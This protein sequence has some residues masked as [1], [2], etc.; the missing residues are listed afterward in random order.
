MYVLVSNVIGL[1]GVLI[2]AYFIGAFIPTLAMS[3]ILLILRPNA[4]GAHCNNSFNCSLFGYIIMPLLGYGAFWLSRCPLYVQVIFLV[5]S[6]C[7]GLIWIAL[8]APYF[9]QYKPQAEARNKKLK[10][11]SAILAAVAFVVA[12]GL[13]KMGRDTW[14]MGMATGLFFQGLVLSPAGI[15]GILYLDKFASKVIPGKGGEL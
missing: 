12:L 3:V 13:L 11:R 7:S 8:K 9:T 14:A 6:A 4:G 2:V 15:K 1:A 10:I 5:G